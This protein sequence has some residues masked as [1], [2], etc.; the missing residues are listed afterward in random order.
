[1]KVLSEAMQRRTKEE[2]PATHKNIKCLSTVS[3][4]KMQTV[5]GLFVFFSRVNRYMLLH[6]YTM[7]SSRLSPGLPYTLNHFTDFAYFYLA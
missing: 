4:Y 6:M 3:D 7:C 2:N 1:M 5:V